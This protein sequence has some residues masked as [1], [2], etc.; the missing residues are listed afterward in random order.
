[1]VKSRSEICKDY[2][3]RL[4]QEDNEGY[5]RKERERRRKNYVSTSLLSP[6]EKVDR[7]RKIREA[8][9]KCREKKKRL[10]QQDN[11][12]VE[13]VINTSGYESVQS[14]NSGPGNL[15]VA[16]GFPNRAAGP[17][18]RL[19]KQLKQAKD[20]ISKLK[21][22]NIELAK[23]LKTEQ[24][25]RQ[26]MVKRLKKSPN[27][28]RSKAEHLM[29][30]AGLTRPQKDKVRK[31]IIFGDVVT[32]Q[33]R[34]NKINPRKASVNNVSKL[35]AGKI[36]KKY[37][38]NVLLSKKLGVSKNTITKYTNA[39][40]KM[41]PEKI[42]VV[43]KFEKEIVE[44]L[45]RDDNSR[46]QPGKADA[47]K[48]E[49]E[50]KQVRVLT[51]YMQNLHQKFTSENTS[52]NVSFAT[53]CRVRPKNI[54]LSAFIVRSSCLCTK[55]Q[56]MSLT[57]KTL[58]REGVPV[59]VNPEVFVKSTI[60]QETISDTLP[61][62]IQVP[63]WK[64]VEVEERGKRKLVM[65]VVD[66][67]M[68]KED[69]LNHIDTQ[70]QTFSDHV[71]RVK[72][73]YTEIRNLK[74]NLPD[75]HVV[76]HMDFAENFSCRNSDE[77]QSAYFNQ[78]SVTLHPV[79]LYFKE[80]NELKHKSIV[81][82]S[83]TLGHNANTVVTFMDTII[84][85]VKQVVPNV[86][87]CHYWTDSP[88]SQY[89][90]KIIFDTVANHNALYGCDAV[91]N[92]FES[93]HG[94]GPCDGLGG[95][96][97]RLADTA[98]KT[99]NAVI[100]DATDFF[101]WANEK[102]SC[103][104]VLFRYVEESAITDK[105]GKVSQYLND[106]RPIKGTMKLHAIAGNGKSS[107]FVRET[108]CYCLNCLSGERCDTWRK[109]TTRKKPPTVN[110]DTTENSESLRDDA[111]DT[112]DVH[113]QVQVGDYVGAV[114][115]DNWYVGKIETIDENDGE[116]EVSFMERKKQLFQWPRRDDILWLSKGDLLCTIKPPFETGKSKRMYKIADDDLSRCTAMFQS[117][118]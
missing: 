96:V 67:D 5:L 106:L 49:G 82:V 15:I 113:V 104:N 102:S 109:E 66:T 42:K 110:T 79:V 7:R 118:K 92:Y 88:T 45:E 58:R 9:K 93:G 75:D 30:S 84:S 1:M 14:E 52:C 114:Y 4:K 100:Q 99:G 50:L 65:R 91:W 111:D 33:L 62:R 44:F 10:I 77:I 76:I 46:V 103:K 8:V 39:R 13:Q 55:H 36:V 86:K 72:T 107:V 19:T 63:Q 17:R 117:R 41:N 28:P 94:K 56:N 101:V 6:S 27:T 89:R 35:A 73:Q 38:C 23:K 47:V 112:Q 80:N 69:F 87:V 24:R 32:N 95:T 20:T 26:R 105:V 53:F 18:K 54:K 78:T 108:S 22:E 61:E 16:M 11:I 57:A 31:S 83:D 68:T 70:K 2:R 21:N 59:S 97:K 40:P 60:D 34:I 64:R 51:D 74:Q 81:I 48:C 29:N 37:R 115:D 3:K 43:R 71:D 98:I 90:N 25:R 12:N 85:E 116:V